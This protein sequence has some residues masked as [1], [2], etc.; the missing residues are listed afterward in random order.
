MAIFEQTVDPSNFSF[1]TRFEN[2]AALLRKTGHYAEAAKREARAKAIRARHA[3][4]N[5]VE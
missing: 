5:R 3:R 2:C 1:A 4:E